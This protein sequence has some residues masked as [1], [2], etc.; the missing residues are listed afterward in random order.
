VTLPFLRF[1]RLTLTAP[2]LPA[3]KL[4]GAPVE[5]I[6]AA[7]QVREYRLKLRGGQPDLTGQTAGHVVTDDGL[8][9][10]TPI[11]E[12]SSLLRV[13]V[14]RAA[15]SNLSFGPSAEE[16]AAERWV[17][18]PEQLLEALKQQQHARVPLL[19]EALLNLGLL[20]QGQLNRA[21]RGRTSHKRLGE[22][23]VADGLISHHDLET[24]IA[25]KMGYPYVDLTCFPTE[26]AATDLLPL[27]MA[28]RARAIPLMLDGKRLIVAVEKPSRVGKLST[29][30]AFAELTVVPVLALKSHILLALSGATAQDAWAHNVFSHLEFFPTTT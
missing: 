21:L 22:R 5:R 6:P 2:L 26:K 28:L 30:R 15:Y 29:L 14:P 13:F 16:L 1:R 23:L 3:A 19:G 11:E 25:Y 7:A 27:R 24:A 12:D 17:A 10:F 9:L 20:T 4:P 8:F 18:T